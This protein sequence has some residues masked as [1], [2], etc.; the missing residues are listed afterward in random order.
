MKPTTKL[1][2]ALPLIFSAYTAQATC[3]KGHCGTNAT[4]DATATADANATAT[5]TNNQSTDVAVTTGDN[6]AKGGNA[7]ANGGQG[8]SVGP[9]T[10]TGG[11]QSLVVN[12]SKPA[13]SGVSLGSNFIQASND[14]CGWSMGIGGAVGTVT[15]T[16]GLN[17]NL[18]L[19][20][21]TAIA[22]SP[23]EILDMTAKQREVEI[24]QKY[25]LSNSEIEDINCNIKVAERTK[26]TLESAERIAHING[27]YH[28]K[29]TV[30]QQFGQNMLITTEHAC[31]GRVRVA[32]NHDECHTRGKDLLG[33]LK[34]LGGVRYRGNENL[35]G[36][37][38]HSGPTIGPE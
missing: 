30:A 19:P 6:V 12:G 34:E 13:A 2:I 8:G 4:A 25:D 20:S 10:Q 28:L 38:Q 37:I 14:E 32:E 27:E 11:T 24:F 17:V 33:S 21:G 3:P 36:D 5:Q 26:R 15:A 22:E 7:T 9:V 31:H 35:S 16:A 29:A 18:I 1:A 23:F